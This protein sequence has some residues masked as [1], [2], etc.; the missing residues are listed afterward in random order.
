MQETT[1]CSRLSIPSTNRQPVHQTVSLLGLT[2]RGSPPERQSSSTGLA[3]PFKVVQVA[4]RSSE[5]ALRRKVSFS[6]KTRWIA[7]VAVMI[8]LCAGCQCCPLFDQYANVVDN[9]SDT[10]LYFDHLYNPKFDLTRMGKP[11]WC[12]PLNNHFC[13]RCCTNGCYDG[14]DDCNLYP[15]LTPYN[16]P[17]HVMPP[18][19]VRT[20][21][22]Q[23]RLDTEM[24]KELKEHTPPSQSAPSTVPPPPPAPAPAPALDQ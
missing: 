2:R 12:S 18:P 20:K 5:E 16:F 4:G 15:P 1:C 21:R 11:D 8:S 9:A 24:M 6:M 10:H 14:Y 17:S 22:V 13:R 23:R 3:K 19:T 7:I